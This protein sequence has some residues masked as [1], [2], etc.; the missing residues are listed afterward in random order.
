MTPG[1]V[2]LAALVVTEIAYQPAGFDIERALPA[3]AA[4]AEAG[5]SAVD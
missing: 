4:A 1:Y 3:F 5:E 2:D